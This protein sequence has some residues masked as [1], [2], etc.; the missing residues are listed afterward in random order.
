MIFAGVV[1]GRGTSSNLN[2]V[3]EIVTGAWAS[4]ATASTPTYEVFD[5]ARE[6]INASAVSQT[7]ADVTLV[8]A[9]S[10]V[11]QTRAPTGKFSGPVVTSL[12]SSPTTFQV[13]GVI[14]RFAAASAGSTENRRVPSR[15]ASEAT[16]LILYAYQYG[17]RL[18][19]AQALS[20]AE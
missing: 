4:D 5:P 7:N 6:S 3:V 18:S 9:V 1:V 12:E 14:V 19:F 11:L 17:G 20:G 10:P 16:G 13:M 8:A 2:F 15:A